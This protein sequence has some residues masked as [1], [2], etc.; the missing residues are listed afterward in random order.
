MLRSLH[1]IRWAEVL[2]RMAADF[3]IIH[4]SI[5]GAFAISVA[6]QSRV[7]DSAEAQHV[8]SGFFNYYTGL[9]CILSP[10]FPFVFLLNGFY[11][12]SRAYLGRYKTWVVVRGVAMAGAVFFTANCLLASNGIAGR[13]VAVPFALLAAAGT[14]SMRVLK[15]QLDKRYVV[16]SKGKP[17]RALY[18]AKV[19]VVGGAGYIGSLLVERLLQ[20]GYRVRVLDSLIYGDDAL[21][22]VK[23]HPDFELFVGDCRNIQDVVRAVRGVDSIVHLAAIVGDPACNQER[24]SALET[25]YAATRMLIEIAKGQDV[26]RFLFASS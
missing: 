2:P 17:S 26:R 8:I 24:E 4:L 9:F 6:Y 10:I 5:I 25:N 11:T 1:N 22:P 23:Y 15:H 3:L 19:L 18:S 20:K 12:H 16:H 7:G 21:R 13:S 14:A